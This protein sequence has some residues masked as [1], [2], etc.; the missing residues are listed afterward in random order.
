MDELTKKADWEREKARSLI[1]L[2]R[3]PGRAG[4]VSG[5]Q[6]LDLKRAIAA[7]E[8]VRAGMTELRKA[9]A[10]DA[11]RG[12]RRPSKN[13]RALSMKPKSGWDDSSRPIEV[14][15]MVVYGSANGSGNGGSDQRK[16]RPNV[17]GEIP[18]E[19]NEFLVGNPIPAQAGYQ[20][21]T[22]D[23]RAIA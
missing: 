16:G 18:A 3:N 10:F 2:S 17:R 8:K 13:S 22:A 14:R 11:D 1:G 7:E 5:A 15:R 21:R 20:V 9:G 6:P 12:L 23:R 19:L 4:P